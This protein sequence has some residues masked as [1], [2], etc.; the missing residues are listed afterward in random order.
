MGYSEI[1]NGED[2]VIRCKDTPIADDKASCLPFQQSG[3]Y[4]STSWRNTD[5]QEYQ[6]VY[7][8]C[9]AF[10]ESLV[11]EGCYE[12]SGPNGA[13]KVCKTWCGKNQCNT[14][15][16]DQLTSTTTTTTTTTTTPEVEETTAV[17]TEATTLTTSAA[18][19]LFYSSLLVILLFC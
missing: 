4:A 16:A 19:T 15:E 3:C 2:G 7:R 14:D 12:S 9:S 17:S 8:G 13:L 5:G 11:D 6:E 1:P 18:E 10:P